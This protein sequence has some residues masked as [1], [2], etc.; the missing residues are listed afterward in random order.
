MPT[1]DPSGIAPVI[2]EVMRIRPKSILD[3]GVGMGKWGLLFREYLEGWGHHRYCPEQWQVK[4][5]GIE[6]YEPYVQSWHHD[7]YDAVQIGD[8]RLLLPALPRVE[9]AYLG[10][11]IEHMSMEDGHKLLKNI[12]AKH[13][14]ISTPNFKT[15]SNRGKINKWQKHLCQWSSKDLKGYKHQILLEKRLLIARI[16]K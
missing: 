11:V 7:I 10:D 2:K 15:S 16:D 9:L 8:A 12:K 4:L 5:Y 6:A 1:S 14:I 13:I 3:V